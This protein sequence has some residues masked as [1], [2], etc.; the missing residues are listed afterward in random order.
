MHYVSLEPGATCRTER[1]SLN[2]CNQ[3][4]V[5]SNPIRSMLR[6]AGSAARSRPPRFRREVVEQGVGV[7]LG[8]HA[9]TAGT[10]ERAVVR[11]DQLRA[12]P[13][14]LRIISLQVDAPLVP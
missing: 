3:G 9:D 13:V 14:H 2:L 11:I 10:T 7:G 5:G 4:V 8:P 12:L 1:L 6:S